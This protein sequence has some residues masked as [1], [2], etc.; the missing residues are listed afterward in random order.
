MLANLDA[1]RSRSP[2]RE[3]VAGDAATV[4][5]DPPLLRQLLQNLIGNAL[6]FRRPDDRRRVVARR[7]PARRR[8]LASSPSPTTASAS[9]P[10][11]PSKVFVIFQRLHAQDDYA[12]TGIGLA[13]CKKIVEYHGGRIWLD[14]DDAERHLFRF[15][16][17]AE[18]PR[19]RP[20]TPTRRSRDA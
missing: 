6:K 17:P 11:T 7:R 18:P 1:A 9:S 3:I 14:T 10:S 16:L 13:M 5:G 12:G 2:A 20:G 4:H 8:R 15:T 19:G